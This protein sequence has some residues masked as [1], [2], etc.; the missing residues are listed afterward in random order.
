MSRDIRNVAKLLADPNPPQPLRAVLRAGGID[1]Q[2]RAAFGKTLA[3][4]TAAVRNAQPGALA[5]NPRRPT[6]LRRQLAE[7][8]AQAITTPQGQNAVL[9]Q[10][11]AGLS[12]AM[13]QV[14]RHGLIA[15][16]LGFIMTDSLPQPGACRRVTE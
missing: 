8:P 12:G 3:E 1:A 2:V 16:V 4:V 7:I 6:A 9:A 15:V 13:N 14:F 10:P 5:A 11:G